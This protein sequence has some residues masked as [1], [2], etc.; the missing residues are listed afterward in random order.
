MRSSSPTSAFMKPRV[1]E[2]VRVRSTEA[3]GIL[4]SRY[5]MPLA[6]ASVLAQ[7]DARQFGICEQGERNL[8]ACGDTIA[9]D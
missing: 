8:S 4:K 6:L 5:A 9:S 7:S 1:S 2:S 3:I